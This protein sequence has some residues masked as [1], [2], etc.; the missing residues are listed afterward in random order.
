M[1]SRNPTTKRSLRAP[2]MKEPEVGEGSSL[3]ATKQLEYTLSLELINKTK[4][5]K[6]FIH[7]PAFGD[8]EARKRSKMELPHW[9]EIFNNINQEEYP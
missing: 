4:T 5:K 7:P 2:K 1:S 6:V 9:G 8:T 3:G